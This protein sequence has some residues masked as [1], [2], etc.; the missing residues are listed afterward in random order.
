MIW[1]FLLGVIAGW[2]APAAE[3]RLRPVVEDNLP[4]QK[5]APAEMRAIAL[6]VCVLGAAI[7]AALS[8]SGGAVALALGVVIGVLGPR[9]QARFRAMRAPDYDS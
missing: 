9:L 1:T 2:A 3:D 4:G 5:P 7:V 8:G 6:S